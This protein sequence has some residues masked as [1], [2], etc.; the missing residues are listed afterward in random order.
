MEEKL[1]ARAQE[2]GFDLLGISPPSP[3]RQAVE[4]Y[5]EWAAQGYHG[6]M[7]YM[8]RPDRMA[9]RSDPSLILPGIR[10]VVCV[11]VNYS[12]PRT[13]L[14]ADS[15]LRGRVSNY[16]WGVD[17]HDWMLPRLEELGGFLVA[18]AG[19]G[20]YRAYV[21]TGPVLERGLAWQAGLGFIG[22]NCSL[23][24]PRRGSY[25]FLG[26][27]LT[28][29]PLPP[30]TAPMPNR[31][32]TCTRCLDACPTGALVEPRQ[33][34]ARRCISYLTI[35][36][37]GPIPPAMRPLVGNW[38]Y[39]CDLCQTVCPWQRFARPATT[40]AFCSAMAERAYPS[41]VELMGLDE[42][43]FAGRFQGSPVERIGRGRL[44]RNA[45]VALGNLGDPKA[46]PALEESLSDPDPLVRG[47]AAWALGRIGTTRALQRLAAAR[48]MEA[49]PMVRQELASALE[50]RR[51]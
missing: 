8:V 4:T 17:Y 23:I 46:V 38:I 51:I 19:G 28:D 1:A 45:A 42:A 33:M 47:H 16:A 25:L 36:L 49:D 39:G 10:S 3:P 21:D 35:E 30:A 7:G 44:L 22:K 2:L 32:S 18:G 6:E 31:C 50:M 5:R 24:H 40:P 27:I 14:P 12:P 48:E 43:G 41:L 13:A 20:R 15:P 11:A 9:R 29:I 26:V 37:K 34:D